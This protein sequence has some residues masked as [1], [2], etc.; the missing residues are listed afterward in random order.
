MKISLEGNTVV[1]QLSSKILRPYQV[2]QLIYWGFQRVD[3]LFIHKSINNSNLKLLLRYFETEN[4][5]F[6]INDE[7]K[8]RLELI[9]REEIGFTNLLTYVSEFK[10]GVINNDDY[11]S[12]LDFIHSTITNRELKEHQKKASFHLYHS[13]NGANF[14]VPG[15]GKTTVVLSVFERLRLEGTVNTLFIIGPPSSFGPWK[16]EFLLVLGRDANQIVL[17]GGNRKERKLKYYSTHSISE[18]YLTTFQSLANDRLEVADFLKH[19]DVKAFV[20]IDEAHYIKQID[21]FWAEA[22]KSIANYAVKRCVLTGTP[23][24]HRLTDVFNLFDFLWP[25][26]QALPQSS[27]ARIRLFEE[28]HDLDGAIDLLDSAIGPLFYRVRKSDLNLRPQMFHD[29]IQIKMNN[30]ERQIYE[31]IEKKIGAFS[32]KDIYIKNIDFINKLKR[33]RIIRLRQTVSYPKLLLSAIEDY[34]EN[35]LEDL[36][37]IKYLILRYDKLEMPGKLEYLLKFVNELVRKGKK[38]IIWSNFLG[39]ISLIT[40]H[41]GTKNI[42]CKEI[43]GNTP[44]ETTAVSVEETREDIVNEFVDIHSGLNV[45]VL[46]PQACAESISLHKTCYAAIYYDLSYSCAQYLQSL[47]R[48]HRVGG[49]EFKDAHYY[50]LQYENSIDADILDN[51]RGKAEIMSSIIDKDYAVYSLNMLDSG[52]ELEAYNRL[53]NN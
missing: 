29:P 10:K 26:M 17:A 52:D 22:V 44:I 34:N 50:F 28:S 36:E 24:P 25:N 51:V 15:S 8:A 20:V 9:E 33:G 5:D 31:A 27:K 21:G 35:M 39:S 30:Y 18:L 23:L 47:D 12:H 7:L 46:N 2:S 4:I 3:K 32:K 49:S 41:L 42:Y 6:S 1:C 45:L 48:I 11:L 40:D 43:V 16:N 14:S 53:F 38:V 13:Q 19:P 37:D